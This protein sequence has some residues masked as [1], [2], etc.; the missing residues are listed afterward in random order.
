MSGVL[1]SWAQPYLTKRF[2]TDLTA[3]PLIQPGY[4]PE[5]W[6]GL[7]RHLRTHD[8]T[9]Q[10]MTLAGV[11]TRTRRSG[12]LIDLFRDRATFPITD[13]DGVI[14][15]FVARRHPDADDDTSGPKYLNTRE[16][17][18]FHKGDQFYG[19]LQPDTIPVIV[20]G[21]MD[22]I[23]VTLAGHGRYTGLAP[24]GT[25]LTDPQASLL[26]GQAQVIIAT[27]ADQAGRA[28]ACRD[29]W[30]L[31]PWGIDPHLAHLPG[32]TDPASVLTTFGPDT[33]QVI[34]DNATPAANQMI[35][36]LIAGLPPDQALGQAARILAA[37][38]AET[39]QP[40]T[41]ELSQ[42]LHVNPEI[43]RAVLAEH[44]GTWNADPRQASTSFGRD[45]AE[46]RRRLSDAGSVAHST[47]I[48]GRRDST[49]LARP[50]LAETGQVA[51]ADSGRSTQTSPRR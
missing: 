25:A 29:Y 49:T 4:A 15:G 30:Q 5:G 23:A 32:G 45:D 31:T 51:V 20:E 27:D 10:E 34:L 12:G 33:L 37:R 50:G 35:N 14:L 8:I 13:P 2:P 11:A 36:N 46:L 17:P 48:G 16:T 41:V 22:A 9:D 39:W 43:V 42:T 47:T 6:T 26:Y 24:L 44:V 28:A 18:L 38:P 3:D 19:T 40:T 7:V 21:P 1:G